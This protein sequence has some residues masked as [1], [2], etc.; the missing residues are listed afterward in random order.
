MI[1]DK[2][3]DEVVDNLPEHPKFMHSN[4]NVNVDE[5]K[6]IM[7]NESMPN[8][9]NHYFYSSAN[10]AEYAASA[11][12]IFNKAG[13][14]V[15]RVDDILNMGIYITSAVKWSKEEAIIPSEM[16]KKYSFLL[17]EE[18]KLFRDLKVIMLMGDVAKKSMNI[19]SKRN[20]KKNVIPSIATYKIRQNDFFYKDIQVI[21]SYIMTGPNLLLEKNKMNMIVEDVQKGLRILK[22]L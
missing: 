9:I 1:I 14:E 13:E 20:T 18:L 16:V 17:E 21:P 6:M 22:L 11:V 3:L 5:I 7:I 19:I 15:S 2:Y 8:N 12:S 10:N 4:I